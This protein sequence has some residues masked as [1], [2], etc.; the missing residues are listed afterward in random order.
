[1]DK[2]YELYNVSCHARLGASGTSL[3]MLIETANA[4]GVALARNPA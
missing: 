3:G 4:C 1:M 2:T